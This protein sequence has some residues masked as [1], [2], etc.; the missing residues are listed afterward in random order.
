[1]VSFKNP[2]VVRKA[3][4]RGIIK[5]ESQKEEKNSNKK[6]TKGIELIKVKD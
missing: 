4:C 2:G 6:K 3:Q 5:S 1:V